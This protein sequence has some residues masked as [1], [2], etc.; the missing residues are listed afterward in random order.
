[1]GIENC[2]SCFPVVSDVLV[3]EDVLGTRVTATAV[4]NDC[5]GYGVD[6]LGLRWLVWRLDA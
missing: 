6:L 3:F 5:L 2:K 4:G 1:M